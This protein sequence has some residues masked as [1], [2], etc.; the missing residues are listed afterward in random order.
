MKLNITLVFI[1][2][3]CARNMPAFLAERLHQALKVSLEISY[4]F[5]VSLQEN[6]KKYCIIAMEFHVPSLLGW[7][8]FLSRRLTVS[9]VIILEIGTVKH[10]LNYLPHF[11]VSGGRKT[12][13]RTPDLKP[14]PLGL[15]ALQLPFLN[16]VESAAFLVIETLGFLVCCCCSTVRSLSTGSFLSSGPCPEPGTLYWTFPLEVP[17]CLQSSVQSEHILSLTSPATQGPSLSLGRSPQCVAQQELALPDSLKWLTLWSSP[18]RHPQAC[19]LCLS[20]FGLLSAPDYAKCLPTSGSSR[21]SP[22]LPGTDLLQ[23]DLW[24]AP[25]RLSGHLLRE[26]FPD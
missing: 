21:L 10:W 6:I 2:V 3:H 5:L 15:L 13:V 20:H 25:S 14:D 1:T 23:I 22:S 18:P 16:R 8:L 19:R 12:W 24:L 11:T 9:I 7:V 4:T 26:V 17:M